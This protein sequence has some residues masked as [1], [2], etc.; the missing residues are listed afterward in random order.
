MTHSPETQPCLCPSRE[1]GSFWRSDLSSVYHLGSPEPSQVTRFPPR[2]MAAL[3]FPLAHVRPCVTWKQLMCPNEVGLKR[4]T[5]GNPAVLASGLMAPRG[6]R[7]E[8]INPADSKQAS[9]LGEQFP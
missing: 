1:S 3:P 6:R 5:V 7:P 8:L 2:T 4:E 9:P